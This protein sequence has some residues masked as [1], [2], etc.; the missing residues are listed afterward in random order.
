[1]KPRKS[2]LLVSDTTVLYSAL[3]YKGPE[4]NLL[5]SGRHV[6]VTTQFNASEIYRIVT[7]KRGFG[8]TEAIELMGSM[9]VL[10]VDNDSILGKWKE[11]EDLIG[12]RDTSD[13]PLV[14][15]ALTIRDHDG[16]W[17]TDKDFEAVKSRFKVWKTG[18]LLKQ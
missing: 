15:L 5:F 1:M 7:Q 17:S 10:V 16:I 9:P 13:V 3:A 12:G 11:A 14:A 8:H 18:E 6:F 2:L 4:N